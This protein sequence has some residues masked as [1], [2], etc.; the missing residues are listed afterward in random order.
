MIAKIEYLRNEN[1]NL[2]SKS[3]NEYYQ[4]VNRKLNDPS[5]SSKT[6]LSIMKTFLNGVKVPVIPPLLFN[7]AF[8]T[9]FQ[10]KSNTFFA[11]HCTLVSNSNFQ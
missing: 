1:D 3:K 8:A 4:N 6:C 11:K 5:A 2:I 7:G 9:D 10:K